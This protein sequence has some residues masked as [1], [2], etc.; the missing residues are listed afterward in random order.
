MHNSKS[1]IS[2]VFLFMLT[3][4]SCD[5]STN[6]KDCQQ[7]R[8]GSF[9]YHP[10]LTNKEEFFHPVSLDKDFYYTIS[11]NDSTEVKM[12]Q[13][14]GTYTKYRIQWKNNCK[15]DLILVESTDSF[16]L[17]RK[18]QVINNEI[19]SWTDNY[20]VFKASSLL[21]SYLTLDTLWIKK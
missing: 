7:F 9:L 18:N 19:I 3:I 21:D 20:L 12:N 6:K 1:F 10:M 13:K 11:H 4:F 2:I 16:E 14:T 5:L 15:Y 8:N 17:L